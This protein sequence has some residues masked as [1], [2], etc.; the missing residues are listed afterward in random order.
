MAS[1]GHWQFVGLDVENLAAGK[2]AEQHEVLEL[3]NRIAAVHVHPGDC[4]LCAEQ[5]IELSVLGD[6]IRHRRIAATL[7]EV[8]GRAT[9]EPEAPLPLVPA[10]V[11]PRRREAQLLDDVLADVGHEQIGV[12]RIPAEPLRVADTGDVDFAERRGI[13]VAHEWIGGRHAILAV[14]AVST[15]RIN[16][17]NL[18][19]RR[20]EVLP[21]PERIPTAA[22]ISDTDVE[23][24][25]IGTARTRERVEAQVATVVVGERLLEPKQLARWTTVVGRSRGFLAVHSKSAVACVLPPPPGRKSG[26]GAVL[27]CWS[28][29]T[30]CRSRECRSGRTADGR[31][32]SESRAPDPS[33]GR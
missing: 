7:R 30:A 15:E 6:R 12:S 26:V 11:R 13:A 31:Q 9:D 8:D 33:T 21:E 3:P 2:I 10:K 5:R 1:G 29:C 22:T 14:G 19:E 4:G 20:G 24:P 28:R 23:Q 25:E 32:S 16:P 18:S 27:L 17:Q